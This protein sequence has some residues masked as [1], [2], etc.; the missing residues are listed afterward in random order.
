MT[1]H[2]ANLDGVAVNAM[3]AE[4]A[5]YRARPPMAGS[6]L[7]AESGNDV[8]SLKFVHFDSLQMNIQCLRSQLE[9]ITET[10]ISAAV[11]YFD[12]RY[13]VHCVA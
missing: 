9:E 6:T 5:N 10:N 4:I 7:R 2:A 8:V 3:S 12:E 1:G 13:A 11:E